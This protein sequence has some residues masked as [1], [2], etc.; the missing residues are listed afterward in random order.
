MIDTL[1]KMQELL[2]I[3]QSDME[4]VKN[5]SKWKAAAQRIRKNSIEFG[6]LAKQFRRESIAESKK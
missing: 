2:T 5:S 1:T 4:K 3:M 6:K